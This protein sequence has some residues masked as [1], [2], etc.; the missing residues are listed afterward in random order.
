MKRIILAAGMLAALVPA[1]RVS[2]APAAPTAAPA[3]DPAF[4]KVWARTDEL[5]RGGSAGRSW[6]WGQYPFARVSEPFAGV[7][8]GVRTVEYYDKSRMEI[9]DPNAD[10]N[11]PWFVTNGLLVKEMISGLVAT[12]LDQT[13]QHAPS[14]QPVVGDAVATNPAPSY[15]ALGNVASLFGNN[16]APNRVGTQVADTLD[17]A[18]AV[19]TNTVLAQ[20]PGTRL[21]TYV[22][23]SGHNVPDVFW[24]YEKAQ[25]QVLNGRSLATARLMDPV[26]VLG[27]PISEPYWVRA[28]IGDAVKD[29][30]IQ[31]FERRIL[32]YTPSNAAAWQVEMGNVGRHYYEWRYGA[33]KPGLLPAPA[34]ATRIVSQALRVNTTIIPTYVQN[35]AWQVA[36]YAAGWLYGTSQPGQPGNS[37]F[38]G[39]N[40]WHGEVFRYLE[41][42]HVGDEFTIYTSDGA[43]HLYRV[44]EIY[45]VQEKGISL[46]QQLQHAHYT[47]Q[48]ADER[49]TLITCWPYT[50]YT[51]RLIV[52]GKPV[53]P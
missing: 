33:D 3:S 23:A 49:V 19:G 13:E 4:V 26:Y 44:S 6:Y 45:K 27:Y 39:H 41:F 24:N 17:A 14:T 38:A 22:E 35:N 8:G 37:V 34:V 53:A 51:H 28:Q 7:P 43:A 50:T 25:G 32:A 30:L 12:G 42:G 52:V 5:V 47:D 16:R 48:T 18:G 46:S 10:R 40:N 31:A 11:S 1:L 20:K 15:A 9:S 2:A 21:G 36:D 29:V